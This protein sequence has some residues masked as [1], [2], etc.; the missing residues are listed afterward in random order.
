MGGTDG[1]AGASGRI[2]G[3]RGRSTNGKT[4]RG[5]KPRRGRD[6]VSSTR[7]SAR[8][9]CWT[10]RHR[11][12]S[13]C[14]T[15]G[16]NARWCRSP[17]GSA[18]PR[19]RAWSTPSRATGPGARPGF[20]TACATAA[21]RRWGRILRALAAAHPNI[22]LRVAHSGFPSP[23]GRRTGILAPLPRAAGSPIVRWEAGGG[24]AP[25]QPGQV[26]KEAAVTSLARVAAASQPAH[27]LG[28][29][30]RDPVAA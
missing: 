1:G 30:P 20:V 10:R 8:A 15:P 14:S 3:E 2:G 26:R 19:C 18:S 28:F 9:T 23:P 16:A 11:P 21:R 7:P 6:R 24:R 12:G 5:W 25:R 27:P 4:A 13:S 29:D 22:T 17:A